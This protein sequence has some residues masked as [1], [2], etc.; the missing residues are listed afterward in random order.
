MKWVSW[1]IA[2]P[3]I[4]SCTTS[5]S[6]T[7][8][9][10]KNALDEN[11]Y[12]TLATI[13]QIPLRVQSD[14][15]LAIIV[16]SLSE[17]SNALFN[18]L[19]TSTITTSRFPGVATASTVQPLAYSVDQNGEVILPLA[20]KVRLAGM[21]LQEA[22]TLLEKQLSRY[23]K[24]PT[25]TIR[26]LNHKFTLIGEVNRPGIYNIV[27]KTNTLPEVISMAGELTLFGRRDNVM[28]IRTVNNKREIVKLDLTSRQVLNSPYYYIENND[29]IY[30]ESKSGRVTSSDRTLQ[31]IP[32]VLST[33]T[34]TLLIYN[35]FLK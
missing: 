29:V 5:K 28:L 26:L 10:T 25:V 12:A 30:V 18:V 21:T 35:T 23:I 34:T 33:I 4:C 19:N 7:Y 24:D 16:N 1:V 3:L 8:F 32:T 9:Q 20:G 17:E 31:L 14:D 27:D 11:R 15:L 6:I 22:G 13:E 2:L